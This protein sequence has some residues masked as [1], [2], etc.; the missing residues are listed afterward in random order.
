MRM[1]VALMAERGFDS[2]LSCVYGDFAVNVV[3]Q[4]ESGFRMGSIAPSGVQP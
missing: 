2:G 1:L 4:I 3:T